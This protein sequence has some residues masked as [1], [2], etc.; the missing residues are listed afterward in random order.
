M[1][2]QLVPWIGSD[3]SHLIQSSCIG[4]N[5]PKHPLVHRSLRV[6]AIAG[7]PADVSKIDALFDEAC[8]L[9]QEA[10]GNGVARSL[11]F[12]RRGLV[13]LRDSWLMVRVLRLIEQD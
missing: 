4:F 6:R 3:E 2:P 12:L 11:G 8:D 5:S 10:V 7:R 13:D 1:K 9:L